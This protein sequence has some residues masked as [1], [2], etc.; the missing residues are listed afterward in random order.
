MGK[1]T[2][3][4]MKPSLIVLFLLLSSFQVIH[5]QISDD[6]VIQ[7]HCA[8]PVAQMNDYISFMASRK[9]T[10]DNRRYYKAKALNLFIGEGFSY[11][12]NDIKKDGV[13]TRISSINRK[14]TT[15]KLTR[16]YF[17]ELINNCRLDVKIE[18]T[19]IAKIKVS[20]LQQI[21]DSTFVCTCQYDQAFVGYRDGRPIYKDITTK[22][23][24]CLINSI[25]TEDGTEYIIKLGDIYALATKRM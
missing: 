17:D 18:S 15:N 14:N 9:K 6:E 11:E 20:H 24:K 5:A 25:D 23:V 22:H 2:K 10:I 3:Q 8:H 7:S 19:E 16:Q 13:I 21:D 12:E 1:S 4:I